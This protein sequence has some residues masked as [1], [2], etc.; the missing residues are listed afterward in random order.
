MEREAVHRLRRELRGLLR[1]LIEVARQD[2]PI[3]GA[4][5]GVLLSFVEG[6]TLHHADR[7]FDHGE[8]ALLARRLASQASTP[9]GMAQSM[10][11]L[12]MQALRQAAVDHPERVALVRR[13]LEAMMTL[14]ALPSGRPRAAHQLMLRTLGAA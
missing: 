2:G 4:E 11:A 12:S 7:T 9:D 14:N 5:L 3:T 13:H 6:W 1:A 10:Q 8:A